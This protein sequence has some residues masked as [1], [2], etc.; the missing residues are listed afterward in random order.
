MRLWSLV[1]AHVDGRATGAR[2]A[3][4]DSRGIQ[5]HT[6]AQ[7]NIGYAPSEWDGLTKSHAQE[8]FAPADLVA[9]GLLFP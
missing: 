8:G 6:T 1:S 4:L 2:R 7:F 3:Y 9:A 5:Q